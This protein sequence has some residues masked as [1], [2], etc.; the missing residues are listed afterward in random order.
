MV[1]DDREWREAE[2]CRCPNA[3]D[4]EQSVRRPK[5]AQHDVTSPVQATDVARAQSNLKPYVKGDARR[6]V[7]AKGTPIKR[8]TVQETNEQTALIEA[9]L[10]QGLSERELRV[11][12]AKK[13]HF[14]SVTRVKTLKARVHEAM[15]L[16]SER[17]RPQSREKQLRRLYAELAEARGKVDPAKPGTYLTKPHWSAVT[18]LEMLI[19]QVEGNFEPIKI[20]VDVVH[21]EALTNVLTSITPDQAAQ[22]ID[23]YDRLATLAAAAAH[24]RGEAM[25]ALLPAP[26]K[27]EI[28]VFTQSTSSAE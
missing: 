12:L 24:A 26:A 28:T 8:Y 9:G 15:K 25:P 4:T 5:R 16:E 21:R 7:P 23:S 19:A 22:L 20:D 11:A 1:V 18:R 27:N 10:I 6:H 13:Q 2:I 14:V 3:S 17:T